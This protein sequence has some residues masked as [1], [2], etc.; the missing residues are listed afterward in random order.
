M[1]TLSELRKQWSNG[2]KG[3]S[4]MAIT[5]KRFSKLDLDVTELISIMDDLYLVVSHIED[6]WPSRQ[7][8]RK[9]LCKMGEI[10]TQYAEKK[11]HM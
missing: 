7:K 1:P 2:K 8:L 4:N 10:L 5:Q 6:D 3:G 11:G 9:G